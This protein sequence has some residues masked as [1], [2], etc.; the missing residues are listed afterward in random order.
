MAPFLDGSGD[1]ALPSLEEVEQLGDDVRDQALRHRVDGALPV[2]PPLRHGAKA[3][4]PLSR[5]PHLHHHR[6]PCRLEQ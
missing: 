3:R 1:G 5:L 4:P 2:E 6:A